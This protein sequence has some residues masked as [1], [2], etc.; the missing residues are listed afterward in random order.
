M[1]Y[2]DFLKP[3]VLAATL[4]F[5]GA[6]YAQNADLPSLDSLYEAA[7]AEGEVVFGG[8]IKEEVGQKLLDAFA[9]KYPGIKVSYTRR[10]TEPMVQL[11]EADKL[12]GKVSFD[13]INLTEPADLVRWKNEGFLAAVPVE[14][15]D[16][17]RENT[18]DTGHHY[19]SLG[20]TPMYG[21][22]NTQS[23]KPEE[24]PKTLKEL[25]TDEKWR[26]KI[27]ISRPT[28]GGTNAIALLNLVKLFGEDAVI[29]KAKEL[30]VLLT[31][32]NEAAVTSVISG[33]RP[34]SWGVSGYRALEA[35]AD[36]APIEL[37]FWE[38]GLPMAMFMGAVPDKAPHPNAARLLLRWLLSEE[39][40]NIII[41]EGNFYSART[42]IT[43]PPGN[44]KPLADIPVAIFPAEE[45]VN[46]G[47]ALA[48]KYDEAV[49]LR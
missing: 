13:V 19:Y 47:H 36:G 26:S 35:R 21:I 11:I 18:F 38:E 30:D 8:A 32:G 17:H 28:R 6:A 27:A 2:L 24:A 49:G 41:K 7:K 12:A 14:N 22:Y 42:D 29:G 4:A 5:T 20:I 46:E 40:Q 37:I 33:E 34:V 10:S 25:I 45:V 44:E 31:R 39:G 3:A 16:K 9:A 23:L 15:N 1:N 48:V 43:T